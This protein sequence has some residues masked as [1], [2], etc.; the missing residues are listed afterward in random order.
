MEEKPF[1]TPGD[2]YEKAGRNLYHMKESPTRQ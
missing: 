1:W 2:T